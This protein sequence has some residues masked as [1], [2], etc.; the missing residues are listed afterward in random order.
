MS[1]PV[2]EMVFFGETLAGCDLASPPD[3]SLIAAPRTAMARLLRLHR[4]AGY[5]TEEAPEISPIRMPGLEQALIEA[6]VGCLDYRE[7][8]PNS[9]G[10]DAK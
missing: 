4:A 8:H 9:L 10:P 6:M 7:V 3:P 1:L 5:L 2:E